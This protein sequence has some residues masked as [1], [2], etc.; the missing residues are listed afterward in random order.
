VSD[1]ERFV[2]IDRRAP[3]VDFCLAY[4]AYPCV[5]YPICVRSDV[6][7]ALRDSRSPVSYFLRRLPPALLFPLFPLGPP[8]RSSARP[9]EDPDRRNAAPRSLLSTSSRRCAVLPLARNFMANFFLEL[10][11]WTLGDCCDSRVAS[12][13]VT[14]RPPSLPPADIAAASWIHS[15]VM[16]RFRECSID[17]SIATL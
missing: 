7:E 14:S 13:R 10:S 5:T 2:A 6:F 1:E 16:A 17:F 11:T 12:N 15:S 9:A 8:R 3:R 4:L